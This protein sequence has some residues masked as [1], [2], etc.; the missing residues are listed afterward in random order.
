LEHADSNGGTWKIQGGRPGGN[1]VVGA[2]MEF[3]P[4][5]YFE[6]D[7]GCL[8]CTQAQAIMSGNFRLS[9]TLSSTKSCVTN[10][11][12]ETP[13]YCGGDTTNNF[14]STLNTCTDVGG[15]ISKGRSWSIDDIVKGRDYI[16]DVQIASSNLSAARALSITFYTDAACTLNPVTK[17]F[18]TYETAPVTVGTVIWRT[19]VNAT[20]MGYDYRYAQITTLTGGPN[21]G[22]TVYHNG[23]FD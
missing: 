4:Y 5:T 7:A 22:V 11:V 2:G 6:I 20:L 17:N 23:Y 16:M 3:T 21:S 14:V 18:A 19:T 10:Y 1:C 13:S 15:F 12:R 8:N 9:G